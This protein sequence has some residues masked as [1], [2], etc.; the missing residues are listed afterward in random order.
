MHAIRFFSLLLL[1]SLGAFAANTPA[2]FEHVRT[3]GGVEEYELS[4]NGLSVLLMPNE[5][6][7][8]ATV[9]VTYQVGSRHEVP[10]KTGATHILEHMM[11][12]GTPRFNAEENNDYSSIMERI[13]ARSNATTWFD[14]T[15]YYAT[16]PSEHVPLAIELEADR[17]RNL[18]IREKD[19]ASEMTVVRNE[20]ERGENN[21]VRTLI[22]ELFATAFMAHTYGHPT[23]GWK[24]DIESTTPAKLR[25]FY[26]TY[27]W[28]ENTVLTVIGGFDRKQTLN[29][30]IEHY[31]QIE[32]APHP[33]PE[34]ETVEPEQIGPR[35]VTIHRAGQVGVVM[36]GYKVP[37]A[38]HED[39]PALLLIDQIVGADKTGRLYRA[40]EDKGKASA[41]FTFAPELHDPGLFVFGAYLTPEATHE[42]VEAILE[43]EIQAL[44]GGGVTQDELNRAKSVIRA[45]IVYGRDGPYAIADQINEAIAMGDW[46]SYINRPKAIEA[47]TAEEIQAVAK[48]YFREKTKTTGWFI[49]ERTNGIAGYAGRNWGP[50]YYRDPE[51]YGPNRNEA[52]EG[53]TAG[54]VDFTSRMRRATVEG[55]EVI[56]VDMPI[57][58]AVSFVGSFAAGDALSPSEQ[59]MLAGLTAAMLDKGST[60][61]D[62]FAIAELL[63]ALGADISFAA[64]GH[65]LNFS[66]RFLRPDAGAVLE[67]LGEQIRQP[68]FDPAV[69]ET[70]RSRQE[71]NLLQAVDDPGYR[72]SSQ[73]SRMLYPAGHPNRNETLQT[74][75]TDLKDTTVDDLRQFHREFYGPKSMR[76]VFAGDIDFEQIKA[77]VANAFEGWSGGVPYPKDPPAQLKNASGTER[78]HIADKTS[79]SVLYGYNTGLRRSEK[80]YLPFMVGNYILGGSFNARLMSEV[81]KERGLTYGIRSFHD[82]D[83]L[84]PGHWA[85][86]ATF[87]P[88]T[89]DEGLDATEAVLQHWYAKGVGEE[90]VDAAVET[91]TGSYLVGLSTTGRVAAQLHSFLQ[92]GLDAGYIDQYPRDLAEVTTGAVN[93]SIKKHLDPA[94][95]KLVIAGSLQNGASSMDEW[96]NKT[97]GVRI[98]TPDAGWQVDIEKIYRTGDQL[99]A[100]SRL[101]RKKGAAAAQ[102]ITTVADNVDI[103]SDIDLPVRHYILGKTWNWGD[104]GKYTFIHSEEAIDAPLGDAELIYTN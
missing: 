95:A 52:A 61:R 15:N 38:T 11:F 89:L 96:K 94:K 75:L 99:I 88:D 104:T 62:R 74:L 19:L 100:V 41:T 70:V 40:L 13:G 51:I 69:F 7:P 55:I 36:A 68:A 20:Y 65:S 72:A 32:S 77:A 91:L 90:E 48:R 82:G 79:V 86:M 10:G 6:L 26:D 9:M 2:G 102:V 50:N 22:K 87:S 16:L 35:R 24:S 80:A 59:P 67:L 37:E 78:I 56:A 92:R 101:S 29:A 58:G 8:V 81:R 54:G 47:V 44:I 73:L 63:D 33:I 21:P 1:S 18:R 46:T 85:L 30:I 45:A 34:V 71:A 49:P 27:Y 97:V 23:I 25:E 64:D 93:R 60:R 43:K 12:K 42:E 83:I 14:R 76:L 5:G 31:G 53:G 3:L 98:D 66:G 103:P 57:E 4:S 28:P 39:W 17:M 84:T